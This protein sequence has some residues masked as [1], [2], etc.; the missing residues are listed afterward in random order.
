[1]NRY[2]PSIDP[3]PQAWLSMDEQIRIELV[4]Q[5]HKRA[6]VRLPSMTAHAAVHAMVENQLAQQY[7]PSVNALKRLQSQGLTR[8][9]AIHAIG[10]V[11]MELYHAACQEPGTAGEFNIQ[12]RFEKTVNRLTARQWLESG[13][14][15]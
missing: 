4:E 10:S 8:H 13:E 9:D 14:K 7:L 5:Y 6:K 11:F 12:D 2:D 3:D 1:M 15:E